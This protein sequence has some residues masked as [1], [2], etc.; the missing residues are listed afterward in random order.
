M[1]YSLRMSRPTLSMI[2]LNS[3]MCVVVST[4][5]QMTK[6]PT[7]EKAFHITGPGDRTKWSLTGY[8]GFRLSVFKNGTVSTTTQYDSPWCKC[9]LL[10]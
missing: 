7:M 2:F 10:R 9:Q 3:I 5:F 8:H 6:S 4:D 1:T